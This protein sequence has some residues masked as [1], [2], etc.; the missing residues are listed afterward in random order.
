MRFGA[1][2]RG[3]ECWRSSRT[4]LTTSSKGPSSRVSPAAAAV[5]EHPPS[6][7]ASPRQSLGPH[8]SGRARH[9]RF[10]D[11]VGRRAGRR[12]SSCPARACCSFGGT[13][14][15]AIARS[16]GPVATGPSSLRYSPRCDFLRSRFWN[17]EREPLAVVLA[18]GPSRN[19]YEASPAGV[20]EGTISPGA[21]GVRLNRWSQR[22]RETCRAVNLDAGKVLEGGKGAILPRGATTCSR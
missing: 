14:A 11:P 1:Y 17:N 22:G 16:P 13:C 20:M 18:P 5:F 2:V 12:R 4:R 10:A 3:A 8:R 15:Q 19:L 7:S 9:R 6:R 21:E